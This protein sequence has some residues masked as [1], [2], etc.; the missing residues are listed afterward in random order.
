MSEDLELDFADITFGGDSDA[1]RGVT[2]TPVKTPEKAKK[3]ER[4]EE[5]K[6]EFSDKNVLLVSTSYGA[7]LNWA[8]VL[9]R[10]D[11]EFGS[12][13]HQSS[14]ASLSHSFKE[15]QCFGFLQFNE[16]EVAE[17]ALEK[18]NNLEID[19]AR[20][21]LERTHRVTPG[22]DPRTHEADSE[23][24][25]TTLVLKNLPFQLKQDKLEEML[26]ALKC[27]PLNVSYLYDGSGTFRGMAFVKYREIEHAT[28]VFEAIN[29]M[30]IAGRKVRVEY[31]R[32]MAEAEPQEDDARKLNEDLIG[33]KGNQGVSEMAFPCATSFQRK[34]LHQLAEK[35]GLTHYSTGEGE[36]RTVIVKKK[37]KEPK[38]KDKEKDNHQ[39]EKDKEERKG[40]PIK[41]VQ[42]T[43]RASKG[44]APRFSSSPE[45]RTGSWDHSKSPSGSSKV[46][47]SFG[48]SPLDRTS[49]GSWRSSPM[50][51][52]VS[53]VGASSL[54]TSPT[55]K[56]SALQH[57][58]SAPESN[59]GLQP[60]R[61]P[62]GPDGTNGFLASYKQSRKASFSSAPVANS[63]PVK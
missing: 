43:R 41:G 52:G 55:Y 28:K 39:K 12:A 33:F 40:Q 25:N 62:K 29:N 46:S 60:V 18:L 38:D 45:D 48:A 50:G 61:Q 21:H 30:D 20:I 19:G 2:L 11:E 8:S 7:A 42:Q 58:L 53:V 27:K 57:R 17:R 13:A 26:N 9:R 14:Q 35:L 1:Q 5:K 23:Y 44:E 34:Q 59:H 3:E 24:K 22:R 37:E 6:E 54:G 49:A 10:V 51:S 15:K 47:K 63:P 4:E 16:T 31:K 36:A 32:V 56:N